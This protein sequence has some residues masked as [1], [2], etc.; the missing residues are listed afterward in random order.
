[1]DQ[2][3]FFPSAVAAT[4]L[5]ETAK[6]IEMSLTKKISILNFLRNFMITSHSSP[7]TVVYTTAS[8][9]FGPIAKLM[10]AAHEDG[11]LPA[12]RPPVI[13][14]QFQQH[15]AITNLPQGLLMSATTMR[16]SNGL[17]QHSIHVSACDVLDCVCVVGYGPCV[18]PWVLDF[19]RS[20]LGENEVLHLVFASQLSK[21][22]FP[23]TIFFDSILEVS[24]RGSQSAPLD[25]G[26]LRLPW[27]LCAQI[28]NFTR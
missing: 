16:L 11:T 7:D 5:A 19:T 2:M 27:W 6:G 9:Y 10:K 13:I 4:A 22:C 3:Y 15:S 26:A 20:M 8:S 1:M 14:K 12:P 24:Q 21:Q 28:A 25:V 17:Y 18:S 23:A